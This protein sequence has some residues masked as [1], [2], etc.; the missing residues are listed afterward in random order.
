MR[1][2]GDTENLAKVDSQWITGLSGPALQERLS[3][4]GST[5]SIIFF[6][7]YLDIPTTVGPSRR[8]RMIL[9]S[10]YVRFVPR[11]AMD[12]VTTRHRI[13]GISAKKFKA[14]DAQPPAFQIIG[15]VSCQGPC[16]PPPPAPFVSPFPL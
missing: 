15:L 3:K 11:A 10:R 16:L 7:G 6:T 14:G 5:L 9:R 12:Q 13:D 2:S 4:L 8:V 1:S